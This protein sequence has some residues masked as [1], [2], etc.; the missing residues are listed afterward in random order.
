MFCRNCGGELPDG[1][2]FCD[3]CGY[4]FEAH[5][6][7]GSRSGIDGRNR[8]SGELESGVTV[9]GKYRIE[10]ELGR[11]GMALVY[12]ATDTAL[13][14]PVALKVLPQHYTFDGDFVDRFVREARSSAKVQHPNIVTIYEAGEADG[15]YYIA[16]SLIAGETLSARLEK[17]RVDEKE[18]VRIAGKIALALDHAHEKSLVH[19]D[20]KPGNIIIRET[21][22]E[23]IL[24]DFGI[25]RAGEGTKITRTGMTVGTPEYMSPEQ[26]EGGNIGPASDLYSLGVVLYQ[27]LAGE[28]PFTGTTTSVLYRHVH[29]VAPSLL[30]KNPEVTPGIAGVVHG[31]LSKSAAERL[32]SGRQLYEALQSPDQHMEYICES[33][34]R[35]VVESAKTRLLST[36]PEEPEDEQDVVVIE[37]ES[38]DTSYETP[39]AERVRELRGSEVQHTE[40]VDQQIGQIDIIPKVV[41]GLNIVIA[42]I[43]TGMVI[44]GLLFVTFLLEAMSGEI[45]DMDAVLGFSVFGLIHWTFGVYLIHRRLQQLTGN[46]YPITSAESFWYHA[47]PF[48]NLYWLFKWNMELSKFVNVQNK[49]KMASGKLLGGLLL[50]LILLRKLDTILFMLP[51]FGITLY[52]AIKIK[53]LALCYRGI[54]DIKFE[55][56]I[57]TGESLG[58]QGKIITNSAVSP[59]NRGNNFAQAGDYS[60]AVECFNQA[61]ADQPGFTEAIFNR[62]NAYLN[63]GELGG[64]I[65]DFSAVIES[66]PDFADAYY[67]R[68]IS[69]N[70]AGDN[71]KACKDLRK[72]LEMR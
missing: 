60:K 54:K 15:I 53:K 6:V 12:R 17:E 26:I 40:T 65:E 46:K 35:V 56:L 41:K 36:Q 3:K 70:R 23:P 58:D 18:A 57:Q 55:G 38:E 66:N 68:G 16:M 8:R 31:L 50:G 51:M 59:F 37:E 21:D 22:N 30:E 11:G 10:E 7:G 71:D 5:T 44:S 29:E 72:Y 52:V 33:P 19:R 61:I 48:Y 63:M 25:A 49:N 14:R 9:A 42:V 64:A 43:F 27:M 69:Y 34:D 67:N 20:I 32:Q 1:S 28:A 13:G 24:M 62:G 47:I 2:R 4:S 45:T 39:E